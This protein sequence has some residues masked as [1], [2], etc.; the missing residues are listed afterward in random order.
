MRD[1]Y[2]SVR[3]CVMSNGRSLE[4][5]SGR[6]L[7]DRKIGREFRIGPSETSTMVRNRAR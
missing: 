6:C 2:H 1:M 7:Y 4:K 3:R 5:Q